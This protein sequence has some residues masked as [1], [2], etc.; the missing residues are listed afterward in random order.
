MKD[1]SL[2]V[3]DL[4]CHVTC[5]Q[6]VDVFSW[7][8][9]LTPEQSLANKMNPWRPQTHPLLSTCSSWQK[10]YKRVKSTLQ[11]SWSR[12]ERKY[13]VSISKLKNKQ[14]TERKINDKI[15]KLRTARTYIIQGI[16]NL[17]HNK[18][19]VHAIWSYKAKK[20]TEITLTASHSLSCSGEYT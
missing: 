20:S 14:W 18:R 16:S 9:L 5:E 13:L 19:S 11:P 15:S 2:E 4:S 6:M 8:A 12:F 3:I 17:S 10:R 7:S 1:L